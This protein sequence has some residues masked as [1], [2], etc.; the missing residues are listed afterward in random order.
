MPV[1]AVS[2][3]SQKLLKNIAGLSNSVLLVE[4]QKQRA[5]FGSAVLALVE[6]PEAWPKETGI[7]DLQSFLGVLSLF[8]KPAIQFDADAMVITN[9]PKGAAQTVRYRYSDPTT[10]RAIPSKTFPTDN[11]SV[12][13]T[14]SET[15]L[16]QLKK[17]AL[18]LKIPAVTVTVKDGGV[19]LV[20]SDPKIPTSHT[21]KIDVPPE[22]DVKFH[23]AGYERA[24]P[25]SVEHVGLLL[26]GA[27]TVSL[28]SWKYAFFQ[29]KT[30]PASYFIAEQVDKK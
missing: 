17:T 6:F 8:S 25:L 23:K 11:P 3:T 19:T 24:I 13:F 9:E 22:S 29:H 18:M 7:Y 10:I 5:A 14:L 16:A 2:E 1:F 4:G 30:A 21:F 15:A 26:E 12:E 27:Y 28:A 20:A